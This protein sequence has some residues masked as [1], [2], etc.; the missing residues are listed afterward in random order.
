MD[1]MGGYGIVKNHF[2][3]NPR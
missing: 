1:P 3:S 2:R